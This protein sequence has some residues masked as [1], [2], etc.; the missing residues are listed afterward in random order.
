MTSFV[1]K[2]PS[3]LVISSNRKSDIWRRKKLKDYCAQTIP[4]LIRGLPKKGRATVWVGVTKRTRGRYD[5]TNLSDTLKPV[6]DEL[7]KGG[8]LE[9]D[10]HAHV[11]GPWL[12]HRSVDPKLRGVVGFTV[13]LTDY[14][15]DFVPF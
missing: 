13:Y 6:V 2:V 5:P 10:D 1:F 9:D 7:V 15:D 14:R 11:L 4:Y 8:V 3:E 12:F